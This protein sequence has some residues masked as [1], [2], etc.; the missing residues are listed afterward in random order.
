MPH[1][2]EKLPKGSVFGGLI[3]RSPMLWK[4]CM[5]A[6]DT[7]QISKSTAH[8]TGEISCLNLL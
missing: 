1:I 3:V 8:S 4:M 5:I 7:G 2:Y 6:Q